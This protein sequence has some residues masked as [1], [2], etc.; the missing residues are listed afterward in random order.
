LTAAL[1]VA[2]FAA[3][4]PAQ[5]LPVVSW[6][7]GSPVSDKVQHVVGFAALGGAVGLLFNRVLMGLIG[8]LAFGAL[9]EV[10][11]ATSGL[12]RDGDVVDLAANAAGLLAAL[13]A[14]LGARALRWVFLKRPRA[15][16]P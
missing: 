15:V 6:P 7:D 4:A 11:Q 12:G 1:A 16:P 9:L 10:V 8:L 13:L 2:A 3:I 5:A 14:I